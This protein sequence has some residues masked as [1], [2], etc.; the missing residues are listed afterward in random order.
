[1]S[2]PLTLRVGP[3]KAEL[4]DGARTALVRAGPK[5]RL[6]IT[7]WHGTGTVA[8]AAAFPEGGPVRAVSRGLVPSVEGRKEAVQ[9]LSTRKDAFEAAEAGR[10]VRPA[11]VLETLRP[12]QRISGCAVTWNT[13]SSPANF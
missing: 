8:F 11:V 4:C 13:A 3:V 12:G 7:E 5:G 10:T 2:Q 6:H 9:E 1:M